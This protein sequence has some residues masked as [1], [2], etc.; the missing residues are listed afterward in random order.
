MIE[1]GSVQ[2]FVQKD[3]L[4]MCYERSSE[5]LRSSSLMGG[6]HGWRFA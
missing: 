6:I 3:F 2:I 5:D 4:C 1:S